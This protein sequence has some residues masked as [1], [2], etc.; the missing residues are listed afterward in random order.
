MTT[1]P[2]EYNDDQFLTLQE[3]SEWLRV[4]QERVREWIREGKLKAFR[5]SGNRGRF[6][7]RCK[8]VREFVEKEASGSP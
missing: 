3:A 8:W 2:S 7:I 5:T 6:L 4:R 1:S